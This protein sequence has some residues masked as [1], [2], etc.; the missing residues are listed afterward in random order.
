MSKEDFLKLKK[1]LYYCCIAEMS[2]TK[3][4]P[5]FKVFD[6]T[7]MLSLLSILGDE[8]F[9]KSKNH[10]EVSLVFINLFSRIDSTIDT[11]ETLSEKQLKKQYKDIFKEYFDCG[12]KNIKLTSDQFKR[13]VNG[14]KGSQNRYVDLLYKKQEIFYNLL[15]EKVIESGIRWS[16]PHKAVKACSKEIEEAFNNFDRQ[17]IHSQIDHKKAYLLEIPSEW[18][19]ITEEWIVNDEPLVKGKQLL[20]V[21]RVLTITTDNNKI[22]AETHKTNLEIKNLKIALDNTSEGIKMMC[23]L[24]PYHYHN[25]VS[26]TD[27]MLI[28]LLRK[29]KELLEKI[30][31]QKCP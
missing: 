1:D 28:R 27:E 12:F 30:I 9:L 18:Q 5:D 17:W 15:S 6:D 7:N 24:V 26:Y 4:N 20:A 8:T 14:Y 25:D 2:Y 19:T 13:K 3:R 31:I 29:N 21:N 23:K 22:K 11:V 10:K 16:N